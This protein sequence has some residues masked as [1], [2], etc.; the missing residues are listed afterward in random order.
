MSFELE[1]SNILSRI[2]KSQ[3]GSVDAHILE[4]VTSL[5]AI[6]DYVTTS[7]CSGRIVLLS[8]D[9][10]FDKQNT[11][12]EFVSHNPVHEDLWP[13]V[14]S[15]P[16]NQLWFRYEGAILHLK[17][18]DTDVARA[19]VN[20]ARNTGFKRT[21]IMSLRNHPVIELTSSEGINVPLIIDGKLMVDENYLANLTTLANTMLSRNHKKLNA[22]RQSLSQ[23]PSE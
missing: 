11:K 14:Q 8:T 9:N 12:W 18:R 3:K 20:L 17:S 5:N 19:F 16:S 10:S 4:L 21:G 7:S 2:D 23:P 6:P 1:K 15:S 22:V 13:K